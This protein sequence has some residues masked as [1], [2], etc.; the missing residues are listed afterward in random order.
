MI[1]KKQDVI[2]GKYQPKKKQN[3]KIYKFIENKLSEGG[4]ELFK[5]CST[6]NQFISTRDKEK[7]K[8][9]LLQSLKKHKHVYKIRLSFNKF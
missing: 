4:R 6:F 9:V 3:L 2:V 8:L 7:S 5:D 1:N